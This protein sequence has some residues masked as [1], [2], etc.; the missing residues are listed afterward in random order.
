VIS[1]HW[2]KSIVRAE[3]KRLYRTISADELVKHV[4]KDLT[5]TETKDVVGQ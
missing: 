3:W 4:P 1:N 5:Y 2:Y